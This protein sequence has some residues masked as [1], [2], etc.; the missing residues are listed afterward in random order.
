MLKSNKAT[1]GIVFVFVFINFSSM[2]FF[3][4]CNLTIHYRILL[5]QQLIWFRSGL[6]FLNLAMH[7]LP[8]CNEREKKDSSCK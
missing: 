5:N 1:N 7:Q 2:S 4:E 6:V 8:V 3:N